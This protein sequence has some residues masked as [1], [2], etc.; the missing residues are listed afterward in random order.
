MTEVPDA[1]AVPEADAEPAASPPAVSADAIRYARL[2]GILGL[3][4]AGLLVAGLVLVH[5][6]PGLGVSDAQFA[7]FYSAGG[8]SDFVTVGL[9]LVPF[10][11]IAFLWHLTTK[12]LLL[13]ELVGS[14]ARIP[15]ALQ[16][17]GG[18][19]FVGLLFCGTASAG[20]VA[21]IADFTNGP[22]PAAAMLLPTTV[23]PATV[24][25]FPGWVALVGVIVL[26]RA[27]RS[28]ARSRRGG[29]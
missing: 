17:L 18:A 4:F 21:L 10:A 27:G 19:L 29:A 6:S 8:T 3:V 25:V 22:L 20:A 16:V 5:R 2:T 23:N 28:G 15:F 1:V 13:R 9:H 24:L 7:S 26:V 14:P 12:R 11:G